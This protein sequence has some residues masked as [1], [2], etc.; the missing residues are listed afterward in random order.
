MISVDGAPE[1]PLHSLTEEELTAVKK[2]MREKLSRGM[3]E[4]YSIHPEEYS[5]L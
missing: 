1:V 3:S 4:Y 5:A 2:S